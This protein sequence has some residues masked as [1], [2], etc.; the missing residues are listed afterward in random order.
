M[1]KK[2]NEKGNSLASYCISSVSKKLDGKYSLSSNYKVNW[3]F[4]MEV[5][6]AN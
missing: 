1:Y 6:E 3:T 2:T 5:K 4:Y